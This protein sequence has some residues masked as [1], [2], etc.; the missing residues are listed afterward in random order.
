MYF[1]YISVE[2]V[3]LREHYG[4]KSWRDWRFY[5]YTWRHCVLRRDI[6]LRDLSEGIKYFK[7]TA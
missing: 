3:S 4:L 2:Y 6:G 5:I 1:L 7:K